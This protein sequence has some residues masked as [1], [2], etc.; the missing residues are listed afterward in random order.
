M[1]QTYM[2]TWHPAALFQ[3]KSRTIRSFLHHCSK[4]VAIAK[5][6]RPD[7]LPTILYNPTQA[8]AKK[9]LASWDG[10]TVDIETVSVKDT[11][12]KSIAAG[13]GDIVLV[14]SI[15]DPRAKTR[16]K[17]LMEA[18]ASRK[19]KVFQN[20]EFDVGVLVDNGWEI[21]LDTI[22][23]TML[24]NQM[25][26]PDELVNLSFLASMV[27]DIEAW[28]HIRASDP[29]QLLF[30]NALDVWTTEKVY[31]TP[32]DIDLVTVEMSRYVEFRM[33]TLW[34]TII[35]LNRAGVK[36][37]RVA[38]RRLQLDWAKKAKTW[39][40]R[41]IKHCKGL[42]SEP[43]LGWSGGKKTG[44]WTSNVSNK[45]AKELL[46]N[47][48]GLPTMKD[49]KTGAES[50][51][52]NALEKLEDLD[53]SGT[54]TL[55][56][57][58]SRFKD[59]ETPCKI[60]ADRDGLVRSRFVFGGDE[61]HDILEVGKEGPASGRLASR[62][63]NLQNIK[64]W[65]R[66]I[67]ISRFRGGWL[68]K[69]DYSQIE[70]RLIA[71]FSGDTE[72]QEAIETDAHLYLMWLV[73]QET[74][75]HGLHKRG[76]PWLLKHAEDPAVK[77]ARKEQKKVNFGWPYLMGAKKIENHYGVPFARAKAALG[78]LNKRFHRV[79]DWQNGLLAEVR[80][81]S[82]G[83][84]W[85]HLTNSFGRIRRFFPDDKPAM[86]AFKPSSTAADVLYDA[87]G[88]LTKRM[89]QF[90]SILC[91]T[92]HDEVVIDT[93]RPEVIEPVVREI[94]ERPV[95]VLNDMVIPVAI[96][97]GRNWATRTKANPDGQRPFEE[98]KETQ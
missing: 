97:V 78:G 89:A 40:A 92:V 4:A 21:P 82:K 63:P 3:D 57:E 70:M 28:K 35:P 85:G 66:L 46:Y 23:D 44:T 43:I 83:T 81:T 49:P 34:E 52:A 37:D 75:L 36:L 55:L 88:E 8:V 94:M 47:Q 22:W 53:T 93:K 60:K 1:K 18:I 84:G 9:L 7:K 72:L 45:R 5:G 98:W 29:S 15:Q 95:E 69:A 77:A 80:K 56:L 65:V 61:K 10:F 13:Q 12:M 96:T 90:S 79:V 33:P 48:L 11:S 41:L 19:R 54:V 58:R 91:L 73:D 68:L 74:D 39:R 50:V 59:V 16:L 6:K 25:L 42:G 2:T 51:G 24:E 87:M 32:H 20:A 64:E 17:P 67:F 62:E 31:D 86:C 14:W 30:Y 76:W 38:Q 27:T 26:F 71:H